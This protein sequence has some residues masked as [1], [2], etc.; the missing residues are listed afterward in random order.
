MNILCHK[1]SIEELPATTSLVDEL[2][3][4][5]SLNLRSLSGESQFSIRP[6]F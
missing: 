5:A 3:V 1:S 4:C 6:L 2:K